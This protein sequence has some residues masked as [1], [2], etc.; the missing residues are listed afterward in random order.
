M[1]G[2]GEMAQQRTALAALGQEPGLVASI[3]MVAVT[4]TIW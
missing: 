2:A 3:H 1:E 4:V